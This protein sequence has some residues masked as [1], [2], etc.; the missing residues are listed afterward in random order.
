MYFRLGISNFA[1]WQQILGAIEASGI[2]Q[3]KSIS[4]SWLQNFPFF[5]L[6]II[7]C[8]REVFHLL[9]CEFFFCITCELLLW[10]R[11]PSRGAQRELDEVV[12]SEV[13]LVWSILALLG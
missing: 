6:H 11:F 9:W 1:F 12:S 8:S 4:I 13:F 2:T 7:L 10:C 5:V 3:M